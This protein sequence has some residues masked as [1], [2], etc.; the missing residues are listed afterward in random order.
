MLSTHSEDTDVARLPV[1]ARILLWCEAIAPSQKHEPYVT[2]LQS[3]GSK[4][5]PTD[6]QFEVLPIRT[7]FVLRVI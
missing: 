6:C 7:L 1:S 4:K 3:F 2:V 5:N